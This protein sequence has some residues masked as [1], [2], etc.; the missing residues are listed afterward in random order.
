LSI[1]VSVIAATDVRVIEKTIERALQPDGAI[2]TGLG[3][4]GT[5][6]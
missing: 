5:G 2:A 3:M 6:L 4:A 1:G